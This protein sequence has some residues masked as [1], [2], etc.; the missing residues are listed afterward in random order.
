MQL[1]NSGNIKCTAWGKKFE[2]FLQNIYARHKIPFKKLN[3]KGLHIEGQ[4][5]TVRFLKDTFAFIRRP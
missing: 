1:L 4:I 3:D 2:I 5:S